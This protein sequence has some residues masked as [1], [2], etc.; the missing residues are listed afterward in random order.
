MRITTTIVGLAI[1]VAGL[2]AAAQQVFKCVDAK[3][4][5]SYQSDPCPDTHT[6]AKAWDAKPDPVPAYRPAQATY[7]QQSVQEQRSYSSSR[8]S[9]GPV[10]A[11]SHVA[12][13]NGAC[14]AAKAR[15]RATFDANPN[16]S[17]KL[18]QFFDEQV[19]REC[20]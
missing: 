12:S 3:G 15:R 4:S 14:E 16:R 2:P 19:A 7:Q 17:Y 8:S 5:T 13:D 18:S 11:V 10:G 1:M 9:G 20:K 6:V